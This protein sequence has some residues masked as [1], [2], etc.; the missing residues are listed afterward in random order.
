MTPFYLNFPDKATGH[1]ALLKTEFL[2]LLDGILYTHP[3]L[4]ILGHRRT[5]PIWAKGADL[6]GPATTR[7]VILNDWRCNLL[8]EFLPKELVP[9]SVHPDT[10][11]VV[12]MGYE[13][14]KE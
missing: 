8:A 7:S 14:V 5:Q 3:N 6:T 12:F 4:V 11:D 2:L 1:S 9:F 10:P 13:K